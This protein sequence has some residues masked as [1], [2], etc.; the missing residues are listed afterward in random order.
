MSAEGNDTAP[1]HNRK[2]PIVANDYD[3]IKFASDVI[4]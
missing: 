3:Q 4:A 2:I 1:L